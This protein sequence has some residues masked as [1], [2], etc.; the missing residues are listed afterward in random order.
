MW[1][2]SE[3]CWLVICKNKKF[4]SQ[5]NE[6]F[7]HRI[8]LGQTDA[9]SPRPALSGNLAVRC[10]RCGEEYVYEPAEVMRYEESLPDSFTPHPLF[11]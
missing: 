8:L 9:F 11:R 2:T 7:G 4:H 1:D 3:Y 5:E 6:L 10:D